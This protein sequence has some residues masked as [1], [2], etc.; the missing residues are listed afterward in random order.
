MHSTLAILGLQLPRRELEAL[1]MAYGAPG[2]GDSTTA[3]SSFFRYRA[4]CADI[5]ELEAAARKEKEPRRCADLPLAKLL[6]AIKAKARS[7][8][9]ELFDAFAEKHRGG[10]GGRVRRSTM[11][12]TM[13]ALGFLLKDS[14]IDILCKAFCDDRGFDYRR[15][16]LVADPNMA[17]GEEVK[18]K[19][20]PAANNVYFNIHGEVVPHPTLRRPA[21]S[22]LLRH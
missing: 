16:C 3:P 7:R 19:I 9:L 17:E 13:Q 4:F 5:S 20:Q 21:S 14:E 18:A 22:P 8:R 6:N 10:K 15:F 1:E 12:R 11:L 2:P